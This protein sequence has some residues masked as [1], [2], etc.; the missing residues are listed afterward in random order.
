[1]K[2]ENSEEIALLSGRP[3]DKAVLNPMD[4]INCIEK[5]Y[6]KQRPKVPKYCI[7]S[8]FMKGYEFIED[9]YNP[10]IVDFFPPWRHPIYIFKYKELEVS[11]IYPGIGAPY[12][13]AMLEQMIALGA[14][15]F[16]FIGGVGTLTP[17][18]RRGEIILPNKALRDEGTSFHYQKPSRYSY[19]SKLI[20]KYIR[21]SLKQNN[22]PFHEGGT[23]T[24]DAFFRESIQKV[25]KFYNEGC[26]CVEME[27][28]ALFSIAKY[29]NKHIG[30][31]FTAEDCL[32]GGKWD[33]RREPGDEE[34]VEKDRRK[35]VDYALN[36]LYLINKEI[37]R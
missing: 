6:G 31:L 5:M 7:L 13:G 10:R 18:I 23:W 35:L 16:I 15:N 14:D 30:G 21:R 33:P 19:P 3:S 17:K 9:T 28:S 27:A 8:F 12:A 36:A 25:E 20:L 11:Y 34:K 22:V 2:R 26:L 24:T 37:E 4:W 32:A 1:M 29:R